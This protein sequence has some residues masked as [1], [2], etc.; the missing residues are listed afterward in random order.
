M[1]A[2]VDAA[3]VEA[4]AGAA[5]SLI[6]DGARVGL[7]TGRA[8]AAFIAGLADRARAGLAVTCVATSEASARQ[9]RAA[10]L[11]V[12]ALDE[13]GE[14]DITVDGADE[15]TPD[16]DLVK[17]RGGAFVRERIVAAASRRQVI[18]VGPEKLV[19]TLGA[20]GPIPVEVI[21]MALGFGTRRLIAIGMHV[22]PRLDESGRHFVSDNG[23]LVI[24]VAP[25][26]PFA[27]VNAARAFD[28]AVRA[29]QGIV[30]TG[31]FFGT[32]ETVLIGY[33]DGRVDTRHRTH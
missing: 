1:K 17:G 28:G 22:A 19:T 9:A 18:I 33:P 7:G 13:A 29:I 8:A 27:D 11:R 25:A 20:T 14:L 4:A 26:T 23:N 24:D 21:P 32:A 30:D 2:G 5:L 3:G 12:V 15:V 16:L 10:G 31:L 6:Q